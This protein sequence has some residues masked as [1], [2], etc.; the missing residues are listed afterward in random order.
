MVKK[1][2]SVLEAFQIHLV[3][4]VKT[5]KMAIHLLMSHLIINGMSLRHETDCCRKDWI[6]RQEMVQSAVSLG[7]FKMSANFTNILTGGTLVDSSSTRS[8]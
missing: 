1:V 3:C 7:L 4:A 6:L 2:V 5:A 8:I